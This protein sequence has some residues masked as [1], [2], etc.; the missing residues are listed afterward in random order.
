L[1]RIEGRLSVTPIERRIAEARRRTGELGMR[2]LAAEKRLV[3]DNARRLDG[4]A[5]LLESYSYHGVL[6]RGYAVVRDGAGKPI[7]S[8][9]GQ[10][11][12]APLDIEFAED[13]LGAVVAGGTP[14]KPRPAPESKTD[15]PQGSLL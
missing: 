12:G 15:S 7:R 14:E 8:G 13:R 2:A 3:A 9:A 6:K 1:H 10:K 5:K 11:A 4:A